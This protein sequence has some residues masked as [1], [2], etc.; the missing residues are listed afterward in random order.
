MNFMHSQ[1]TTQSDSDSIINMETDS[2]KN[3]SPNHLTSKTKQKRKT[4]IDEVEKV[5]VSLKRVK[6]AAADMDKYQMAQ[7]F[8]YNQ[9]CDKLS[10]YDATKKTVA[11]LTIEKEKISKELEE[12]K[13]QQEK[14]QEL[15]CKIPVNLSQQTSIEQKN[16]E[17]QNELF[18]ITNELE[19]QK[20][21]LHEEVENQNQTLK[22]DLANALAEIDKFKVARKALATANDHIDEMENKNQK[23][24]HALLD[25]INEKFKEKDK[26]IEDI[27]KHWN[28]ASQYFQPNEKNLIEDDDSFLDSVSMISKKTKKSVQSCNSKNTY[29]ERDYSQFS[30][31]PHEYD[32]ITRKIPR[33]KTKNQSWIDWLNDENKIKHIHLMNW[34]SSEQQQMNFDFQLIQAKKFFKKY[35]TRKNSGI[36]YCIHNLISDFLY[37]E[38]KISLAKKSDCENF[39]INTI[40]HSQYQLKA[41]IR[42]LQNHMLFKSKEGRFLKDLHEKAKNNI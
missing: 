37:D 9:I 4:I 33:C 15:S 5:E 7:E 11:E 27:K 1:L 18:K 8:H 36:R 2:F 34:L 25:A 38:F 31:D 32:E 29:Y 3:L 6:I 22:K 24:K 17:L 26:E 12:N 13:K 10:D 21:S 40:H 30:T 20:Q 16:I 39:P 14:N 42:Y 35:T 28:K 23:W 41:Y 19:Q